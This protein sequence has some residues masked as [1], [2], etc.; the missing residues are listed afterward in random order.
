MNGEEPEVGRPLGEV[1][2][3]LNKPFC[4][5]GTDRTQAATDAI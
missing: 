5:V 4:I 3:E 1:V 2:M